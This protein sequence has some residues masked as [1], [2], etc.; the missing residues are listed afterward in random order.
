MVNS[1]ACKCHAGLKVFGLE[2]GH[3]GEDLGGAKSCHKKVQHVTDA[4]AHPA[5]ARPSATLLWVDCDPLE[6]SCHDT[7]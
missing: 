4:D 1:A 7:T 2:V 5:D 3:F 6:E